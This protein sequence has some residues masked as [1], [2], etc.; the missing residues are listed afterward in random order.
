M[1][2]S[3]NGGIGVR[4]PAGN[5][6]GD[7]PP[8]LVVPLL[9]VLKDEDASLYQSLIALSLRPAL[10]SERLD[11]IPEPTAADLAEQTE[12]QQKAIEQLPLSDCA[13][14]S[15]A[16]YLRE[17][18][19]VPLLT[20]EEELTL[21]RRITEGQ[22]ARKRL[23]V[24]PRGCIERRRLQRRVVR[25]EAARIQL[26]RAN[27]RLV[28]SIG[29]RYLGTGLSLGD[30][31][32]EGSFGLLRAAEKFDYLRGFKFSTYATWWIRQAINRS[33]TEHSRAIRLPAYMADQVRRHGH[34]RQRLQQTMGRDPTSEELALE[35]DLI[36]PNHRAA[37]EDARRVGRCLPTGLKDE[38]RRAI[39]KVELLT[40]VAQEPLSLEAP[41]AEDEENVIGDFLGDSQAVTL[42]DFASQTLLEDQMRTVLGELADRERQVLAMRFG[43]NGEQPRTLEDIGIIL[44]VSRERVRQIEAKALRKLRQ[45]SRSNRLKDYLL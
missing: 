41:V 40:Q 2:E 18:A 23:R 1:E 45:P 24:Y 3:R 4:P 19:R 5:G 8:V 44:G 25:G 39:A 27:L 15:M 31:V 13:S 35:M 9:D 14:D 12:E 26:V 43:L 21:G 16:M 37:I 7:D 6:H 36:S 34:L 10:A 28:V 17:I 20:A 38:L 33:I 22:E 42:L 11:S 30:L 32:Q 29:K